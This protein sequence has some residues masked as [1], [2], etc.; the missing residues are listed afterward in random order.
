GGISFT[1][2]HDLDG[3]LTWDGQKWAHS[4]DAENRLIS[5]APDY[6]GT[7]NGATRIDYTYDYMNRR[8]SKTIS[9]MAGRYVSYPPS[10]DDLQGAWSAL[11]TRRFIWD[12]WNIIAEIIIDQTLFTTNISYY[13]W[14]LDLSGTRQGAGGVGGLFCETKTTPSSTNTYYALGDANG[15]VTEYIDNT[16]AIKAHYEYNA[17]GKI[18]AQSGSIAD[19][20]SFRFSTKYYDP[21]TGLYYYGSRYYNPILECWLSRDPITE[22]GGLNLYGFTYN[23][24][25]NFFDILGREASGG[26]GGGTGTTGPKKTFNICSCLRV[27][28]KKLRYKNTVFGKTFDEEIFPPTSK[29]YKKKSWKCPKAF[30]LVIGLKPKGGFGNKYDPNVSGCDKCAVWNGEER[31]RGL[32]GGVNALRY[33]PQV[34][35]SGGNRG[36]K[37]ETLWGYNFG[38]D[39]GIGYVMEATYPVRDGD[40]S[41][42]VSVRVRDLTTNEELGGSRNC[43]FISGESNGSTLT[44]TY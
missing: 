26:N 23:N 8:V 33:Q 30:L 24:P 1:P 43:A 11:E 25:I 20:L 18:T 29:P 19:D 2:T 28:A 17:F 14:G 6:W 38:F 42:T 4:W 37:V 5:S 13:T 32:G 34:Y 44:I 10:Y 12:D 3:N 16:G 27:T 7:T 40:T 15:N 41:I 39:G 35:F 22:D 9:I 31:D 21:E 36:N